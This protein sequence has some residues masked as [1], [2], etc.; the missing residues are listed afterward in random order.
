MSNVFH[1]IEIQNGREITDK[2][3]LKTMER[4]INVLSKLY[5]SAK[6]NGVMASGIAA[7]MTELENCEGEK[8]KN[9]TPK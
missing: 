2:I 1:K 4:A 5:L 8:P 7:S 6:A 3:V 9:L